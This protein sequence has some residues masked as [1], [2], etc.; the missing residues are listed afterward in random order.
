MALN[1]KLVP[2]VA[3]TLAIPATVL[4]VSD[5]AAL[6][7]AAAPSAALGICLAQAAVA[8]LVDPITIPE[9]LVAAVLGQCSQGGVAT[10]EGLITALEDALA[11]PAA[12]VEA[13]S[14]GSGVVPGSAGAFDA[15]RVAR[16]KKVLAAAYAVKAGGAG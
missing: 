8:D 11:S 3:L 14:T 1:L 5:C 12:D 4:G 13:G 9:A 7:P 6:Q 16:L 2:V 15:V 10:V